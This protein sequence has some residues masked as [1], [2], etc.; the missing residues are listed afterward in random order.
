MKQ[1]CFLHQPH[2]IVVPCKKT[3]TLRLNYK[4][5]VVILGIWF[6]DGVQTM[7]FSFNGEQLFATS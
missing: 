4:V 7:A 3:S 5:V 2:G 1:V 6:Y